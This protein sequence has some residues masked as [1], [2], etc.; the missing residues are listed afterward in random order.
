MVALIGGT[1]EAQ[2]R[3]KRILDETRALQPEDRLKRLTL[4]VDAAIRERQLLL[5][6]AVS[7]SR[8]SSDDDD[9]AWDEIGQG[10]VSA[11]S[12]GQGNPALRTLEG[13]TH[14]RDVARDLA[15]E[16]EFAIGMHE[17]LQDY[18]V[19]Q[20]LTWSAVPREIDDEDKAVTRLVTDA[21]K[22]IQEREGWGDFEREL[23]L[24][25]DRDGEGLIRTYPNALGPMRLRYVEPEHVLPPTARR[26]VAPFGVEMLDGDPVAYWIL[27]GDARES[28]RV[29]RYHRGLDVRP[30]YPG[31]PAIIHTKINVDRNM[32]RGWPTTYP[33][34]RNLA[35]AEK[36]LRNMSF[37]AA[38]QAAIALIK[39]YDN[40][41]QS[42]VA[43]ML[44][45]TSDLS[46]N[47][48]TTGKLVEQMEVKPGTVFHA[49]KGQTYEAP[50]SSVNAANN[51]EVLQ[52]DLRGCAV[53]TGFPE[54]LFSGKSSGVAYSSELVKESPFVKKIEGRQG[55]VAR[56]LHT[57]MLASLIHE[58]FMDRLPRGTV[59][60]YE[61]MAEL[62]NPV[63]RDVLQ[64]RQGKQILVSAGVLSRRTWRATEGL[65][66]TTEERNID[67][68]NARGYT[69]I[70]RGAVGPGKP[71]PGSTDGGPGG[72][73]QKPADSAPNGR[74]PGSGSAESGAPAHADPGQPAQA[75]GPA[76]PA[77]AETVQ[78]TALNGAQV[79][80]LQAVVQAVAAKQLPAAAAIEML[81]VAF[82]SIGR[83]RAKV[84]IDAA[85]AFE[86]K[87]EEPKGAAPA[88]F[89]DAER[90]R[91]REQR[92]E[93]QA[94]PD[95]RV[96][97]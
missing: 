89:S 11:R 53:R 57:A 23:V 32:P 3:V 1:S 55:S 59:A 34:R 87:P 74:P 22:R 72:V 67:A 19:G 70:R 15:S 45:G 51:V 25:E 52:A 43:G 36:L 84:M 90:T 29:D 97:E 56:T 40:A 49:A 88:P 76:A 93:G 13:L 46:L 7:V 60:A 86:V 64:D 92:G 61:L 42:Q 69:D 24:R 18:V 38:L 66:D 37:V 95:G 35:R 44:A 10:G 28:S 2:E 79:Q 85:A 14:A 81:V 68:E 47:N 63:V 33:I 12:W 54:F 27:H 96:S 71:P 65:D 73:D 16:N 82:P 94:G 30:G 8:S 39:K 78:D 50:I 31:I 77:G 48:T 58:E 20:G 6:E 75:S 17:R 5:L 41:T 4:E 62:P 80:A 21:I 83:E 26:E 91:I 9:S